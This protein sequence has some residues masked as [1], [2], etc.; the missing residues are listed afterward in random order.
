MNAELP[1]LIQSLSFADIDEPADRMEQ[2]R[3]TMIHRQIE[4]GRFEGELLVAQLAGLQ[5]ARLA[6]TRGIRSVG[7]SPPGMIAIAVPLSVPRMLNWHGHSLSMNQVILQK[8]SRGIDFL[9][10]GAFQLALVSID[11][12][13]LLD[14]AD[15]TNQLHVEPLLLGKACIAQPDETVLS[16][17]RLYFQNLFNLIQMHPQRALQP[18][19]Q[20][21]IRQG[22]ISLMLN[23]LSHQT[24]PTLGPSSRCQLTKQAETMLMEHLDR[25]W[26]IHDL[27]TELHV[28][29]RTLRYGFQE[30]FGMAP[31]TYLKIQR[32]NGARRQLRVSTA[33]QI[34]VTDVAIQWGFWHM[35]QF[36]K[37]YKK[38]FGESPS[39]TLR[40]L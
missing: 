12:A 4:A 33:G 1:S 10:Q 14:A 35:G 28:S 36:A 5:F 8:H 16:R 29:E 22:V 32:L 15:V 26:T 24:S 25:P 30:C 6:Y 7:D 19:M 23:T 31:I 2:F 27:C 39:E 17:F 21:F 37:D 11:I 3:W 34:T 38:M 40:H 13:S 9:R 20:S 18:A